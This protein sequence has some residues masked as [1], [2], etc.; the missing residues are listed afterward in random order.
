LDAPSVSSK[1]IV[2]ATRIGVDYAG[3]WKN[4]PWRFYLKDNPF[5]ST[6]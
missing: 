6:K 4:K 3:E 1:D 5:V 2:E